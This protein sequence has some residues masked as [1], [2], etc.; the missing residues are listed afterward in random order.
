MLGLIEFDWLGDY[1][2][3]TSTDNAGDIGLDWT[4]TRDAGGI[5]NAEMD[6]DSYFYD[7]S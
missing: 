4:A 5:E 2:L 3:W 1:V 7:D 6:T